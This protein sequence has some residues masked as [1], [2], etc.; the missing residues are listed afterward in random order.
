MSR[1]HTR[2]AGLSRVSSITRWVAA[3]G[4]V[5]TGVLAAVAYKVAP[6]RASASVPLVTPGTSSEAPSTTAPGAGST[7]FQAPDQAPVPT[8][9][10]PVVRSGAS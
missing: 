2:D 8:Q 10:A 6:G 9:Q 7:G 1:A 5:A 3:L 4:V